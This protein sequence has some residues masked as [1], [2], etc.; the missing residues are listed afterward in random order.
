MHLRC[1]PTKMLGSIICKQSDFKTRW[2]S[3]W[4]RI[5]YRSSSP[6]DES[7][8]DVWGKVW[9][10]MSS[11]KTM[12][13][14][15]WEWSAIAQALDD[16]LMLRTSTRGLGFAVGKEPL[17]SL[18]ASKGCQITASDYSQSPDSNNWGSTGQLASSLESVHWPKLLPYSTF[19]RR[20]E[21][22]TLT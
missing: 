14:K 3:K 22:K 12:H 6:L 15:V 17:A 5:L 20:V 16:R 10:S 8:Q 13:R 2:Y 4:R 9:E 18:F 7:S 11:A 19:Q 21:F 1:R